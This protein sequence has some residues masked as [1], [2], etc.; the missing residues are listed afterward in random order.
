MAA[1][2]ILFLGR[3]ADGSGPFSFKA[4]AAANG[5][6]NSYCPIRLFGDAASTDS[7]DLKIPKNAIIDDIQSSCA[8]GHI[9]FESDGAP[10]YA[11]IDL[12]SRAN[13]NTGRVTNLGIPLGASH[14]YRIKV[15]VV[16]PA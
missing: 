15:E 9:R 7:V 2:Q 14:N 6:V 8:S 5:A 11:L 3:F 16:L 13:T 12:G 10:T 1:S 4:Y